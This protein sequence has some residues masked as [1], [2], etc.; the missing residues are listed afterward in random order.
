MFLER[1]PPDRLTLL[2]DATDTFLEDVAALME[3]AAWSVREDTAGVVSRELARVFV[4]SQARLRRLQR[5]GLLHDHVDLAICGCCKLPS[6]AN[7]WT[8]HRQ[9]LAAAEW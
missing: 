3:L 6:S 1:L 7:S 9:V 4:P 5:A 2:A 8:L